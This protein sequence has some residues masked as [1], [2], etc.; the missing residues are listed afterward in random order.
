MADK[1]DALAPLLAE[2]E[3]GREKIARAR[4]ELAAE[5]RAMKERGSQ[6]LR[7]IEMERS[8][9]DGIDRALVVHLYWQFPELRVDDIGRAAGI[10]DA[11]QVWRHAGVAPEV[12]VRCARCAT[13]LGTVRPKNRSNATGWPMRRTCDTCVAALDE[14]AARR[15]VRYHVE[16]PDQ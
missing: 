3:E 8:D 2:I 1:I 14:A 4:E 6:A 9:E 13:P 12:P 10:H 7:A 5:E 11:S 16:W 15:W